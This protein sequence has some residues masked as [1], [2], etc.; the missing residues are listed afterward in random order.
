[1][2]CILDVS[3]DPV[4]I[5][6]CDLMMKHLGKLIKTSMEFSQTEI[7]IFFNVKMA[8]DLRVVTSIPFPGTPAPYV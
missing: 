8:E 7:T 2:S 3:F 4:F 6:L 1:M 5:F